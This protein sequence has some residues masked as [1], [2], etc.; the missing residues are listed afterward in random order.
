LVEARPLTGR[1]H[2][3]RIHLFS[4]GH[5]VVGDKLY[6]LKSIKANILAK[7]Q[8]LHAEETDFTLFGKKFRFSAPLPEDFNVFLKNID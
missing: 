1:M 5:P 8:L 2:Q 6:K 3:I 7:R 4:I